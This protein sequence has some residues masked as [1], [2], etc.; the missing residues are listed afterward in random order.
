MRLFP[1]WAA[2][3][4]SSSDG[5]RVKERSSIP[6]VVIA[7]SWIQQPP[8][9]RRALSGSKEPT[10][11]A[12]SVEREF[13]IGNMNWKLELTQTLADALRF[14]IRGALI[15]DGIIL[16]LASIYVTCKLA[17]FLV[18]YLDRVWFSAP[19]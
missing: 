15:L 4:P 1:S 18:R 7:F 9:T 3:P 12:P 8:T 6:A 5:A 17:F 10:V 13:D 19:W 2:A 11:A 16:A 14:C